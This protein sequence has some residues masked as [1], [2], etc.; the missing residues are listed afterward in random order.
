M[1]AVVLDC[2]VVVPWFFPETGHEF[3]Q[4]LFSELTTG[5]VL[6]IAPTLLQVEFANVVWK[7][8]RKNLCDRQTALDQFDRFLRLPIRYAGNEVLVKGALAL[9]SEHGITVYDACYLWLAINGNVILATDD[10]EL[11]R[12]A[13]QVNVR[14]FPEKP[15]L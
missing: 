13:R 4:R 12:V 6:G 15:F 11:R 10:D 9:A 3:S 7:K 1:T 5:T 8:I 2:S 14:L